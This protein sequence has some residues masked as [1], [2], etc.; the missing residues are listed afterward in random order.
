MG[1]ERH[2]CTTFLLVRPVYHS[3]NPFLY[4][5]CMQDNYPTHD[6]CGRSRHKRPRLNR[7]FQCPG[8]EVRLPLH[9]L[10]HILILPSCGTVRAITA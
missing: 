6:A 8:I 1:P 7:H 5:P 4:L 10:E 3:Y 2:N 9:V